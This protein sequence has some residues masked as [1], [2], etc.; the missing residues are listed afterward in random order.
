MSG[1]ITVR[2]SSHTRIFVE[3]T[4]DVTIAVDKSGATVT[5]TECSPNPLD[6]ATP[7]IDHLGLE[8]VAGQI[9]KYKQ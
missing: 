3:S 1:S 7:P 8:D 6:I 4:R 5:V 9:R 2:L